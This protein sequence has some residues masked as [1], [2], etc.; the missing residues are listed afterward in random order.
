MC[1]AALEFEPQATHTWSHLTGGHQESTDGGSGQGGGSG[2]NSTPRPLLIGP[3]DRRETHVP[4]VKISLL[5]F[6][7][8]LHLTCPWAVLPQTFLVMSFPS[9]IKLCHIPTRAFGGSTSGLAPSAGLPSLTLPSN[10]QVTY[11]LP[12]LLR[13]HGVKI[14]GPPDRAAGTALCRC[15]SSKNHPEGQSRHVPTLPKHRTD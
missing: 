2:T 13:C 4:S 3:Q 1:T 14:L 10:S 9:S 7:M 6:P 5:L 11:I 12:A 8:R 15:D